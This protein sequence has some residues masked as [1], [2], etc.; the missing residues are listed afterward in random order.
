MKNVNVPSTVKYKVSR[1]VFSTESQNMMIILKYYFVERKQKRRQ[2][3]DLGR[4]GQTER[5]QFV[6]MA[7]FNNKNMVVIG[8][9]FTIVM[10]DIRT[11]DK[12]STTNRYHER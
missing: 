12:N 5:N 7:I 4:F 2:T 1:S 10:I 3:K 11:F 6:L 9:Y 8:T